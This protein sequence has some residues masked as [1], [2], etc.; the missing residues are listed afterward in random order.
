MMHIA[1]VI[2]F[3]GLVG[4]AAAAHPAAAQQAAN[5]VAADRLLAKAKSL[6]RREGEEEGLTQNQI[7]GIAVGG[8]A[9]L[10]LTGWLIYK[11]KTWVPKTRAARA[12]AVGGR[13][14]SGPSSPSSADE[15]QK[16]IV[17]GASKSK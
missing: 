7:I 6:L 2:V 14:E 15:R 3:F 4:L 12:G 10:I 1:A 16:L 11:Y 5:M 9:F 8:G 13:T 17:A